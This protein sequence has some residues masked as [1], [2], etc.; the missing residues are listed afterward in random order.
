MTHPSINCTDCCLQPDIMKERAGAQR[1]NSKQNRSDI[2][3][4]NNIQ[5]NTSTRVHEHISSRGG[6]L[7]EGIIRGEKSF[8]ISMIFH[9]L[10]KQFSPICLL[11]LS[12][13]CRVF[14]PNKTFDL[15][16]R[17]C[18]WLTKLYS[19]MN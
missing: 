18:F 19:H 16:G 1:A 2:K 15:C 6:F 5:C 7:T 4:L 11:I 17:L 13:D 14:N 10:W 8:N 9:E 3:A 12:K